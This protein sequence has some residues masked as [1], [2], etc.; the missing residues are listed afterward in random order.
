MSHP[1]RYLIRMIVFL[2]AVATV[3][4]VLAPGLQDAFMSNAA[5]NGLILGVMVL[6]I[7][8]ISRAVLVLT[9]EVAWLEHFVQDSLRYPVPPSPS[10]LRRWRQCWASA[11][12]SS[13]FL[14]CQCGRCWTGWAPDSTNR[15]IFTIPYWVANISWPARD[16]LGFAADDR[17][18][19]RRYRQ[20]V[21]RH[22]GTRPG[23]R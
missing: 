21:G 22:K 13:V 5:L 6:G 15:G 3:A 12:N 19:Q 4:L 17:C 11:A 18:G 14:Q 2:A 8:Y 1:R 16:V 20:P 23:V 10:C 7:G 9:R